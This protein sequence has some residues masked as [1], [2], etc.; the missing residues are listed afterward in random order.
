MEIERAERAR[1]LAGWF[2]AAADETGEDD[3]GLMARTARA[4]ER[5]AAAPTQDVPAAVND[6]AR[7]LRDRRRL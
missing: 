5:I 3:G 7:G 6:N 4:L 1:A 2:R